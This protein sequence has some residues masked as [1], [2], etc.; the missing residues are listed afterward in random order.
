MAPDGG[1]SIIVPAYNEAGRIGFC[2][3]ALRAQTVLAPPEVHGPVEIIVVDDGSQDETASVVG[4]YSVQLICQPHRGSAVA[5]NL[6]AAV[7]RGELLLFTDADCRPHPDWAARMAA[8]FADR[9]V[10]A[11]KGLLRSDQ[12]ALVARL[13]QAEYS[14]KETRMLGREQVAFADTAAAA[15]RASV[16]R[17]MGGF[18]EDLPAVED[19]E[20]SFRLAASGHRIVVAP[21]AWV[22]HQHPETLGQYARRK[23]RYGR[24]GARVYLAFPKRLVDDSRTPWSMRFQLVAVPFLLVLSSLIVVSLL[25]GGPTRWLAVPWLATLL[26]YAASVV[27]FAWR[28]RGD[29]AVALAA[30]PIIAVRALAVAAGIVVGLAAGL[31]AR[32]SMAPR[33]AAEEGSLGAV[34]ESFAEGPRIS[35]SPPSEAPGPGPAVEL[36]DGCS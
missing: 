32:R 33:A 16:F 26:A 18:R 27:P 6:G 19:T 30:W 36:G 2:L 22:Y 1:L 21:G 25:Q 7:A 31:V 4:R 14:E 23:F 9:R 13:A 24:W 29:P 15:F 35:A 28:T 20:L 17:E 10:A 5:R 12:R 3:D 34:T 8:V 11:A